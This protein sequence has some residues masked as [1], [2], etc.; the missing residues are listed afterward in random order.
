VA[1]RSGCGGRR[2]DEGWWR[3][4]LTGGG[5]SVAG[6]R[7][8][9]ARTRAV[10]RREEWWRLRTGVV[11]TDMRRSMPLWRGRMAVLPRPANPGMARGSLAADKRT[12]HVSAFPILENLENHLS[13]QEK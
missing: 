2:R 6:R 7:R 10:G 9:G 11:G 13:T 1:E 8:R 3:G 5:W 12:P 4:D